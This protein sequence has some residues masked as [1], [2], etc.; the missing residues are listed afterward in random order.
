MLS[1]CSLASLRFGFGI[2][3]EIISD[4]PFHKALVNTRSVITAATGILDDFSS[5]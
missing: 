4:H 5:C 3:V 2:G 1:I